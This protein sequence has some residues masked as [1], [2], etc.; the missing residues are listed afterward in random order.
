MINFKK[1]LIVFVILFVSS[2]KSQAEINDSIFATVGNKVITRSDIVNEIKIL[3]ISS[4]QEYSDDRLD[5][6]QAAAVKALIKRKIK[7]IEIS[8]YD[9]LEFNPD[10]LFEEINNLARSMNTDLDTL[11]NALTRSRQ[12]NPAS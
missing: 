11:K 7:K 3:L 6:L 4:N 9:N 5:A 12:E 10:D 8:K 1:I 2:L